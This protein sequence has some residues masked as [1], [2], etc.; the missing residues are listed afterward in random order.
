[1]KLDGSY[2]KLN[3][4]SEELMLSEFDV[5][6]FHDAVL[7]PNDSKTFLVAGPDWG[8]NPDDA[9][10]TFYTV[11]VPNEYD[12]AGVVKDTADFSWTFSAKLESKQAQSTKTVENL[13]LDPAEAASLHCHPGAVGGA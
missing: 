4:N 3:I 13:M 2:L 12:Q 8:H 7:L 9:I 10:I 11:Q 1:M 5:K 6:K